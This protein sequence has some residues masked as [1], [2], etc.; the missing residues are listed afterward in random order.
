MLK[1][2]PHFAVFK[3]LLQVSF[4][5]LVGGFNPSEN[6]SQ[7][8]NLPQIGGENKKT[9]ETTTYSFPFEK[10]KKLFLHPWSQKKSHTSTDGCS[11]MFNQRG[12]TNCPR[13][14]CIPPMY[15][16]P[17][18]LLNVTHGVSS[19]CFCLGGPVILKNLS[20]RV[21]SLD[22]WGCSRTCNALL[23]AGM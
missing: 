18:Y 7:I 9:F 14:R 3:V 6:I 19:V 11:Q 20:F 4:S 15:I 2:H 1:R 16:Q 5:K 12:A 21:L 23:H 13:L 17:T 22:V 10:E 8:G